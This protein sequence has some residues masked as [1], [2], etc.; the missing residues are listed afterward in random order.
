MGPVFLGI[1]IMEH[2]EFLMYYPFHHCLVPAVMLTATFRQQG[3]SKEA[4]GKKVYR[5]TFK[6][7]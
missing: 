6:M 2:P 3:N 5:E 1:K 4:L 7:Y